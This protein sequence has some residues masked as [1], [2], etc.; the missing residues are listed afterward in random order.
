MQPITSWYSIRIFSEN[1]KTYHQIRL[2]TLLQQN[3]L[4][5][6]L[7]LLLKLLQLLLLL[8]KKVVFT[9]KSKLNS[10]KVL[11]LS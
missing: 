5:N 2:K 8:Q 7:L 3:K 6:K 9:K 4:N 1:R 11:H 10:S